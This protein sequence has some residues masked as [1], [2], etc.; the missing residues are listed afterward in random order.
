MAAIENWAHYPSLQNA[1]VAISGGATGIG[2]AMVEQFALQGARVAFLDLDERGA[3]ELVN[4]CAK[5]ASH[6][7]KFLNCDLTK[8]DDLRSAIGKV[9]AECGTIRVLVNNAAN[10]DRHK[11]AE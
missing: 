5:S 10:D 9:E 6:S 8:I 7:P 1:V 4:K 2:A 11:T 3:G